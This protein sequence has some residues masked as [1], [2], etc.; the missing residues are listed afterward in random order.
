MQTFA[1]AL[2]AGCLW[3]LMPT[4][5]DHKEWKLVLMIVINAMTST[6]LKHMAAKMGG[7][8]F[9]LMGMAAMSIFSLMVLLM[10]NL[11]RKSTAWQTFFY[12][13]FFVLLDRLL[14]C[15]E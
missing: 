6:Y 8:L 12:A 9:V 13:I 1:A 11:F 4:I 2:L 3:P 14:N 15:F 7:L 10:A 5:P